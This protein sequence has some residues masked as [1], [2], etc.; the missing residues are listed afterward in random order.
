M[1]KHA[2]KTAPVRTDASRDVEINAVRFADGHEVSWA[3]AFPRLRMPVTVPIE[4]R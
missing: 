3:D 4:S 2:A 1:K